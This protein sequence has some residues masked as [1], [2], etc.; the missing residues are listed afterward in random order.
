[1]AL[2]PP[3]SP[4]P[5]SGDS[6]PAG[7]PS[8]GLPSPPGG[9]LPPPP[10]GTGFSRGDS[11]NEEHALK[12]AVKKT[13]EFLSKLGAK[14]STRRKPIGIAVLAVAVAI[15]AWVT[16]WK[17]LLGVPPSASLLQSQFERYLAARDDS[18]YSRSDYQFERKSS[19]GGVF[20]FAATVNHTANEDIFVPSKALTIGQATGLSADELAN[21]GKTPAIVEKS[22]SKGSV[23]KVAGSF[24][25]VLSDTGQWSFDSFKADF[26]GLAQGALLASYGE[27][28]LVA[29]SAQF[30]KA[31]AAYKADA[32]KAIEVAKAEKAAA[33]AAER[34]R[35]AV[36]EAKR[37]RQMA[38]FG[39]GA[40]YEGTLQGGNGPL[41]VKLVFEA[42]EQRGARVVAYLYHGNYP[43]VRKRLVGKSTLGENGEFRLELTSQP[44]GGTLVNNIRNEGYNFFNNDA[45][46]TIAIQGDAQGSLRVDPSWLSFDSLSQEKHVSDVDWTDTRNELRKKAVNGDAQAASDL[47]ADFR[48]GQSGKKNA[49]EG[50]AWLEW[51]G[52]LGKSDDYAI[53]A[54]G[55]ISGKSG[56]KNEQ[57]GLRILQDVASSSPEASFQLGRASYQGAWGVNQN[58]WEA[59]NRFRSAANR[60]HVPAMRAMGL[61]E[62]NGDGIDRNETE[63]ARLIQQAADKGDKKAA[64]IYADIVYK[65]FKGHAPDDAEAARYRALGGAEATA[66]P[67]NVQ[68]GER[69]ATPTDQVAPVGTS[70]GGPTSLKFDLPVNEGWVDTGIDLRN[71]Q[72]VAIQADGQ[73]KMATTIPFMTIPSRPDGL[74]NYDT[75]Q[76]TLKYIAPGLQACALVA[77]VGANGQPFLVGDR[78]SFNNQVEGR[79]YMAPN[80][81]K[82]KGSSGSWQITISVD[83]YAPRVL[84]KI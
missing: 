67:T 40:Q 34:E 35:M 48:L 71:G 4:A 21:L 72:T 80:N 77:K 29:G 73:A 10:N 84:P 59:F 76:Q 61:M 83:G 5:Q 16:P 38:P 20:E 27:G 6:T 68:Q 22:A 19:R 50:S 49:I 25:A 23:V 26:N 12:P 3:P 64:A 28:T 32:L 37:Q 55:F 51:A 41:S 60:S 75:R 1:M 15:A 14:I 74:E 33:E 78:V 79:L 46:H 69:T 2:P 43:W 44:Y 81:F 30:D 8:R 56:W 65:G 31:V 58:K 36:I 82:F 18:R 13:N 66:A 70:G 9:R 63:G 11:G 62:F 57:V 52:S 53:L 17:K 47:A 24:R 45:R 42:I 39:P 54:V 7:K